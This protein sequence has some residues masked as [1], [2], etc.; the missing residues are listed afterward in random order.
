[1]PQ[2]VVGA[3]STVRQGLASLKGLKVTLRDQDVPFSGGGGVSS[4]KP[5]MALVRVSWDHTKRQRKVRKSL[6]ALRDGVASQCGPPL[7]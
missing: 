1:M 6:R 3:R 5:R 4:A 2:K 7:G